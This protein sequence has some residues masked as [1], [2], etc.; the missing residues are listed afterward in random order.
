[1]ADARERVGNHLA[2]DRQLTR[3]CDMAKE[4]PAA[5]RVG[6]RLSPVR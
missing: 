4:I 5:Q 3:V 1:M 6:E 2:L